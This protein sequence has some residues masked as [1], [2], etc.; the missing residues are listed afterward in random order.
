[1]KKGLTLLEILIAAGAVLLL[2]AV[3]V[4]AVLGA[5]R[6]ASDVE[7]IAAARGI[8]AA[9]ERHRHLHGSYPGADALSA[10]IGPVPGYRGTPEGCASDAE[11][12]C[13]SY[14]IAF[15][16]RGPIGG[17]TGGNCTAAPSGIACEA[18]R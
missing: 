3:M 5:R 16:L 11:N 1:M 17:L 9:A 15:V 7:T 14:E 12:A 6:Q 13:R 18:S 2:G 4:V 8:Q 10:E